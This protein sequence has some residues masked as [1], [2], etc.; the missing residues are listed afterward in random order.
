MSSWFTTL[1]EVFSSE[2]WQN[3]VVG[4]IVA[5]SKGAT[6]IPSSKLSDICKPLFDCRP[7]D[8]RVVI[9]GERPYTDRHYSFFS[10]RHQPIA[11]GRAFATHLSSSPLA[12]PSLLHK[13]N[14]TLIEDTGKGIPNGSLDGW[15][16]QGV[17]LL[18][19]QIVVAHQLEWTP[20]IKAVMEHL[21]SLDR[22]IIFVGWG[23]EQQKVI[24]QYINNK[25]HV[26]VKE[27]MPSRWTKAQKPFTHINTA[28]VAAGMKPIHWSK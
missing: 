28:L 5:E 1:K 4:L 10:N 22:P 27:P 9:L 26:V 24:R 11:T 2:W 25:K 12:W 6:V 23:L 17:M 3:T 18:N 13:I 7:E 16:A 20:L 19:T 8:V 14:N 15:V 21:N